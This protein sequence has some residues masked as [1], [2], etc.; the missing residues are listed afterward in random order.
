MSDQ[1]TSPVAVQETASTTFSSEL[2]VPSA[3][4][5]SLQYVQDEVTHS[6]AL[7]VSTAAVGIGTNSLSNSAYRLEVAGPVNNDSLLSVNSGGNQASIN[8]VNSDGRNWHLG[9]GGGAGPHNFFLW[10]DGPERVLTVTSAGDVAVPAGGLSVRGALTVGTSAT[11]TGNAS[12]SGNLTVLGNVAVTGTLTADALQVSRLA[13][14]IPSV[15]TAL[16]PATLATLAIDTTT[17]KLYV[18]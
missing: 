4:G 2:S 15:K 16:E 18:V 9:S 8:L 11:V 14:G 17:G 5:P 10:T 6:S 7:S 12:I 3:L 1:S 13:T